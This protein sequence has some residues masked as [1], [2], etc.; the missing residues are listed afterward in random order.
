M[1]Q[2]TTHERAK[3]S[4]ELPTSLDSDAAALCAGANQR[5]IGDLAELS[6]GTSKR[7]RGSSPSCRWPSS[8]R[9][10]RRRRPGSACSRHGPTP[11]RTP[12]AGIRRRS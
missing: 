2:T 8:I 5:V 11:S 7:A 3:R 10:A 6:I 12:W 9:C 4:F 1:E